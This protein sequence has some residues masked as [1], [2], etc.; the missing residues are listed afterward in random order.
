MG[1]LHLGEGAAALLDVF[2]PG[3][4]KDGV[5]VVVADRLVRHKVRGGVKDHLLSVDEDR[6]AV[7]KLRDVGGIVGGAEAVGIGGSGAGATV[8]LSCRV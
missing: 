5:V 1:N 6:G 3:D 7:Y 8:A 2:L 4:D